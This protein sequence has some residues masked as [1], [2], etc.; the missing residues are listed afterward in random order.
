[1][2]GKIK[3]GSGFK[4]CVNY[5]LLYTSSMLLKGSRFTRFHWMVMNTFGKHLQ[6]ICLGS[7]YV[8]LMALIPV[9]YT[10][11]DVYKRQK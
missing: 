3:K 9:S 11:L 8:T 1:M 6:I 10:H 2:I 7:V 5:C 4:G